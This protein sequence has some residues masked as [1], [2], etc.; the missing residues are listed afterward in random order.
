MGI[1]RK[2][3]IVLDAGIYGI[4]E[5]IFQLI[6]NLANFDLFDGNV[7]K[8]FSTRIYLILGL[9][10]VFKLM[11]SFIQI[12]IEPDKMSDKEKGVGSLLRRVVISLVLIV[13]VP[14]IF[15][16]AKR[17]QNYIIPIIPK[18]VVGVEADVDS[19]N[20]DSNATYTAGNTLD[21]EGNV[22]MSTGRLLAYYSF[23][24]FF[25]YDNDQCND[26][27][28]YGT[29]SDA[30][31]ATIHSVGEAVGPV[32]NKCESSTNPDRYRYNYRLLTSTIVGA[33]LVYVLVTVALQIAIRTIKFGL[34]QVLAPIPIASY[35][36]PKTSK[37]SFD[38][39]VQTSIKVYLDLFT[40][41]IVVYFVIFIFRLLFDQSDQ[42]VV[43]EVTSRLSL[44]M[45]KYGA[46]QGLLLILF[47]ITGLLQFAKQMPKFVSDLLGV[48]D[49]FTDIG[50][51]FKGTGFRA[52]GTTIGGAAGMVANPISSAITNYGL[53]RQK[54]ESRATALRRAVNSGVGGVFRSGKAFVNNEGFSGAYTKAHTT[55]MNNAIRRMNIAEDKRRE[56]DEKHNK[57]YA[58][59]MLN[60]R[61]SSVYGTDFS[62]DVRE[63]NRNRKEI[64]HLSN[65]IVNYDKQVEQLREQARL[66]AAKGD[67][68]KVMN[69]RS[70][71]AQ[72]RAQKTTAEGRKTTLSTANE[73][74]MNN[75]KS[76]AGP[77]FEQLWEN[78]TKDIQHAP[79][80]IQGTITDALNTFT[81]T[82]VPTS[83]SYGKAS[84][85]MGSADN[86]L[87]DWCTLVDKE[88]DKVTEATNKTGKKVS[89]QF[90][91]NKI[92]IADYGKVVSAYIAAT[93]G[94]GPQTL[95]FDILDDKGRVVGTTGP[96]SYDASDLET[97]HKRMQK[98]A[99]MIV[100][101]AIDRGL[102]KDQKR[103][104]AIEDVKTHIARE[105]VVSQNDAAEVNGLLGEGIE[106][107]A[108]KG[109]DLSKRFTRES[110]E[111][112]GREQLKQEKNGNGH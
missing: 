68:A 79:G 4:L 77:Q 105:M 102:L 56:R 1:F 26:G 23:L 101:G 85:L 30:S 106:A 108:G 81:G 31:L 99:A 35:I 28:L 15:S 87:K 112:A 97:I 7:L 53:S 65:E 73:T 54:G 107:L 84:S 19:S 76:V 96:V 5:Q 71:A 92:S 66:A 88:S 104:D 98:S 49:G 9:V 2:I 59:N 13:L 29:T 38:K 47:I 86:L 27:S 91:G 111:R 10:M 39:W 33:Y 74:F 69:L 46:F 48:P 6:I 8:E 70:Q 14:S 78:Y 94:G 100:G 42:L 52:L 17:L 16:T 110:T 60:A 93:S 63:Y 89:A 103:K 72:L 3:F 36:D 51:M 34:C 41:L 22:M 44:I 32:N 40:R 62:A 21:E 24:P 20:V 82:P 90:G 75:V 64:E 43:G 45:G 109:D 58:K 37:Q 61:Y 50:D 18:V 95:T 25:Y 55:S 57:R 80:T 83:S 11:I 67:T 12:L